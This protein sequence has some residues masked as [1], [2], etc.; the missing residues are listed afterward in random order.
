MKLEPRVDSSPRGEPDRESLSD[1]CA[2]VFTVAACW[3]LWLSG[4]ELTWV[5][6][7]GSNGVA[8]TGATDAAALAVATAGALAPEAT[9]GPTEA[10]LD[11]DGLLA[12]DGAGEE[13]VEATGAT[14][15][16]GLLWKPPRD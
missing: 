15:F 4:S 7:F 2:A 10:P 11:N 8:F 16:A 6:D 3:T 14:G 1:W 5:E 12:K 13:K 9:F